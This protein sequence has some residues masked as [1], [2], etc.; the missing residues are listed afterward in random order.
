ML[1]GD[2]ADNIKGVY[3]VG[4][5]K[6]FNLLNSSDSLESMYNI[7][8]AQYT[9]QYAENALQEMKLT[10]S[11]LYMRIRDETFKIPKPKTLS[12][13]NEKQRFLQ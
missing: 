12:Y 2:N 13:D 4:A 5:V 6:A 1:V 7:V 9:Q 3:K 10:F 11:L 8:L